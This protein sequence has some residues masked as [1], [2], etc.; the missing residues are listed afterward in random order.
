MWIRN[1]NCSLGSFLIVAQATSFF[2]PKIIRTCVN[3]TRISR[4][5]TLYTN[6]IDIRISLT[7]TRSLGKFHISNLS[8]VNSRRRPLIVV[9]S[10]IPRLC[11]LP[12]ESVTNFVLIVVFY[13]SPC[14]CLSVSLILFPATT[15]TTKAQNVQFSQA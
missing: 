7:R 5:Y 1:W 14:V 2:I 15:T 3:H 9:V 10:R 8:S 12:S 4:V 13:I 6:H 11:P